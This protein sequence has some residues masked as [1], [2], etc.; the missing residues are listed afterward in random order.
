[1]WKL[2]LINSRRKWKFKKAVSAF[3]PWGTSTMN[4]VGYFVNYFDYGHKCVINILYSY[5]SLRLIKLVIFGTNMLF[6]Y[7]VIKGG[8]C[9]CSWVD[10]WPLHGKF[11]FSNPSLVI[12][13]F[14][15]VKC[16]GSNT[17]YLKIPATILSHKILNSTRYYATIPHPLVYIPP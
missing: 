11:D 6:N 10:P 4:Q 14:F 17:G 16:N 2:W 5:W 1:M 7:H 12:S 9:L 8:G 15:F 13:D 3:E